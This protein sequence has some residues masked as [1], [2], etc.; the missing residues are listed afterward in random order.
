[1]A[2]ESNRFHESIS[3]VIRLLVSLLLPAWGIALVVI[4]FANGLAWWVASGAA[5][6]I[7]GAIIFVGDPLFD[8]H[9]G[10]H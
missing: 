8:F 5:I 1:M 10:E 6:G 9:I 4:G 3:W 2:G 7:A